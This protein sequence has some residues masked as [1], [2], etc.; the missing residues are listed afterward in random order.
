MFK[1][2][3]SGNPSGLPGRPRQSPEMRAIKNLT[4]TYV[5]TIISKLARMDREEMLAWLKTPLVAG[6]PNNLEMMVASIIVKATADGDASKLS[7][8]LDRSIGKVVEERKVEIT[9][10]KYV[11]TVRGDGALM[12]DVVKEALDL[13]EDEQ[14]VK[15]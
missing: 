3:V 8:L 10:V 9:P 5:R 4:P 11:T 15:E 14:E 1:P 6:G 12:Q 7:F 2:G 13:D